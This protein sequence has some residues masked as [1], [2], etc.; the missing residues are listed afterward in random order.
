MVPPAAEGASSP[1]MR[2]CSAVAATGVPGPVVLPADAGVFRWF[3]A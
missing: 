2:G 3:W 1:P